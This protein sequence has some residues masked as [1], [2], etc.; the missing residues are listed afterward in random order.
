MSALKNTNGTSIVQGEAG[1]SDS[2]TE[3]QAS[4]Q[5]SEDNSSRLSRSELLR[6]AAA[7][8]TAVVAGAI[9]VGVGGSRVAKAATNDPTLLGNSGNTANPNLAED[10]TEVQF[11]GAA[12]PGVV[13]LAQ[14]DNT[15]APAAAGFPAAL[16]GW[17]STNPNVPHGV[18]GYSEH[19]QGNA[20]VGWSLA[21]VGGAFAGANRAPLNLHPESVPAPPATG[22]AG[23]LYVTINVD[24]FATLWFHTGVV[25]WRP[26]ALM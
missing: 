15:Y 26:V 4:S 16:A 14:A 21:N 24:G 7:G 3:G 1:R 19:P 13:F 22:Q 25:G 8:V 9:A 17:T 18:Y 20:V 12:S 11:D 6:K 23:D 5:D 10:A 2:G